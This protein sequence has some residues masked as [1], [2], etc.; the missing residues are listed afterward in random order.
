[1]DT[2]SLPQ[3]AKLCWKVGMRFTRAIVTA[4]LGDHQVFGRK[5]NSGACWRLTNMTAWSILH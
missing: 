3:L 5:L 1:M 2:G 4:L